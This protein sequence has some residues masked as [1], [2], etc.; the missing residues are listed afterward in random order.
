M[1]AAS[2]NVRAERSNKVPSFS[3]FN[4]RVSYAVFRRWRLPKRQR[5]GVAEERGSVNHLIRAFWMK[6]GPICIARIPGLRASYRTRIQRMRLAVSRGQM[7]VPT[8]TLSLRGERYPRYGQPE[9]GEAP[10]T[11][12]WHALAGSRRCTPSI[13]CRARSRPS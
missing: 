5:V 13:S 3:D 1:R 4:E 11:A 7:E 6:P 12:G 10:R 9:H 8:V 2:S